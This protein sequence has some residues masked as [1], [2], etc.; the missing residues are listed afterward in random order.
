MSKK[1][2]AK[3]VAPVRKAFDLSSGEPATTAPVGLGSRGFTVSSG[4]KGRQLHDPRIVLIYWGSAW[5]NAATEPSQAEFT[6]AINDL[7]A[8]PWAAQLAKYCGIGPVSLE[9]VVEVPQL[10]PPANFSNQ[11]V[12]T[13]IDGLIARNA[14]PAPSNLVDRIYCVLMPPGCTS[15]DNPESAGRHQHYDRSNGARVYWAW[16]ANDG[17]LTGLNS[18]PTIMS[19]ELVEA[20][21]YPDRN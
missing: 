9:Q 13:F 12:R 4:Y 21:S 16:I 15:L 3:R 2:S 6:A 17:T 19:E 14:V 20:C 10:D 11:W 1:E 5:A 7:F 8:G 18:I